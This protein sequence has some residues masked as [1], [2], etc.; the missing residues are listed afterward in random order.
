MPNPVHQ[1]PE[2]VCAA[3]RL[4]TRHGEGLV[5]VLGHT[6]PLLVPVKATRSRWDFH[7]SQ[8]LKSSD[9]LN[10]AHTTMTAMTLLPRAGR[11][12]LIGNHSFAGC[13]VLYDL[14]LCDLKNEEFVFVED[15]V[16]H[17]AWFFNLSKRTKDIRI[18]VNLEDLQDEK[19]IFNEIRA[20]INAKA[21]AA[22]VLQP[23]VSRPENHDD[24]YINRFFA[25]SVKVNLANKIDRHLPIIILNAETGPSEYTFKQQELDLKNYLKTH[26]DDEAVNNLNRL[27]T[28]LGTYARV[29][30]EIP[31]AVSITTTQ[32][33]D[34]LILQKIKLVGEKIRLLHLLHFI[35]NQDPQVEVLN[36]LYEENKIALAEI[37]VELNDYKPRLGNPLA[38]CLRHQENVVEQ[39]LTIDRTASV[40]KVEKTFLQRN[41][42]EIIG[43]IS[44]S[45]MVAAVAALSVLTYYGAGMLGLVGVLVAACVGGTVFGIAALEVTRLFNHNKPMIKS[46]LESPLKSLK[47]RTKVKAPPEILTPQNFLNRLSKNKGHNGKHHHGHGMRPR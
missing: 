40:K 35:N 20:G 14:R 27:N 34:E 31:G 16:A 8:L 3:I 33:N 36:D 46:A 30:F 10:H 11:M 18:N 43:A 37:D 38:T 42:K 17:H 12:E 1:N 5:K 29:E 24:Y 26:H 2:T 9:N 21:A 47:N 39:M 4:I 15:A 23:P 22:I 32:T 25:I 45:V 44:V 41:K 7:L 28:S 19:H 13:G 6:Y